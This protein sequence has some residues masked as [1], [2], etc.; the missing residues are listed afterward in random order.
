MSQVRRFYWL[1]QPLL[2]VTCGKDGACPILQPVFSGL[3]WRYSVD[4]S[5]TQHV[6]YDYFPHKAAEIDDGVVM[7]E[8]VRRCQACHN[9]KSCQN[10]R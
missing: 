2:S 10:A 7:R 5:G 3:E 1:K 6:Y 9:A 4:D 8:L